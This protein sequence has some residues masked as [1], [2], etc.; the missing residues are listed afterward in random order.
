M[1][2]ILTVIM[3]SA[4]A[5]VCLEPYS[6]PKSYPTSY[7]CMVD[8]YQKSGEKIIEIGPDDVNQHRIYIK[9]ECNEIIIP[10]QKPEVET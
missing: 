6:F 4:Q 5:G 3:C 10:P 9:F 7:E 8:G 1:E 2:F